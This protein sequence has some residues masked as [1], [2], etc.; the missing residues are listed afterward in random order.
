MAKQK[1]ATFVEVDDNT[2]IIKLSLM[3]QLRVA[4][5][6][7]SHDDALELKNDD[8]FAIEEATLRA[9]LE[10]FIYKATAPIREGRRSSVT[11]SISSKFDSVLND[12]LMSKSITKYYYAKV[13][14]PQTEFNVPF[15]I[16]V[17]LTVKY[18]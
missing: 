9:N 18:N 16:L 7:F 13:Y 4:I 17:K 6:K 3:D 8:A 14:R 15:Q 5:N 1:L 2:P 12:T 10:D 11:M